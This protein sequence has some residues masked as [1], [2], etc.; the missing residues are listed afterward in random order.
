MRFDL[1]RCTPLAEKLVVVGHWPTKTQSPQRPSRPMADHYECFSLKR[2]QFL[3]K[4]GKVEAPNFSQIRFAIFTYVFLPFGK[5][6]C[7]F[8]A[9]VNIAERIVWR[10]FELCIFSVRGFGCTLF[11][12]GG[13]N[14]ETGKKMVGSVAD[15]GD[16]GVRRAGGSWR[17]DCEKWHLRQA[18]DLDVG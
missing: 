11:I 12:F 10:Q 4:C 13:K 6:T 17:G 8:L 1:R 15:R 14:N 18:F 9:Y 16:D 3:G 7:S 5:S 2:L